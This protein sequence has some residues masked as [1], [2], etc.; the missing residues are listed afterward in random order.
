MMPRGSIGGCAW[1]A[2]SLA[3]AAAWGQAAP[4]TAQ[5][6]VERCHRHPTVDACDD[7]I[8]WNPRDPSL[9]M[10]MGDAQM[11]ARPAEALRAYQRAAAIAPATPG[12]QQRISKAET[13]VAK[14]KNSATHVTATA[15]T[16]GKRFSNADPETQSH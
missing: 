12:L 6:A 14:S 11:R 2:L 3:C 5:D 4:A 15:S 10:A 16:G 9:L 8:R 13:I 7:A 1:L